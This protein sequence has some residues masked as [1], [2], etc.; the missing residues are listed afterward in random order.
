[1]FLQDTFL[2]KKCTSMQEDRRGN[3]EVIVCMWCGQ[4]YKRVAYG[5]L[6]AKQGP[7]AV[8]QALA[9]EK[10]AIKSMTI[11][12]VC[13]PFESEFPCISTLFFVHFGV[14]W[15][16]SISFSYLWVSAVSAARPQAS[17]HDIITLFINKTVSQSKFTL[18][19][20]SSC[21]RSIGMRS[22]IAYSCCSRV[23]CIRKDQVPCHHQANPPNHSKNSLNNAIV[24]AGVV[25][26]FEYA[27][28]S[29]GIDHLGRAGEIISVPLATLE[30][31]PKISCQTRTRTQTWSPKQNTKVNNCKRCKKK[32]RE[33]QVHSVKN[34]RH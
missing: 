13:A 22:G 11:H 24:G 34:A 4:W 28:S 31:L 7:E 32:T 21:Q 12:C 8:M 15:W 18:F 1:M 29:P 6:G 14:F 33:L 3:C 10:T 26:C 17:V 25:H 19:W 30:P 20:I 23:E 27:V 9:K 2:D 16:I 5:N